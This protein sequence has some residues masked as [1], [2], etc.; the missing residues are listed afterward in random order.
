MHVDF[1]YRYRRVFHFESTPNF[2]QV[3]LGIG[4]NF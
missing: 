3:A 4:V 2:S 1:G